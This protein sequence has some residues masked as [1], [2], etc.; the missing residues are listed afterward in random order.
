MT[1][2]VINIG[3][4]YADAA[5]ILAVDELRTMDQP[6]HDG[7][8]ALLKALG[9]TGVVAGEGEA[10]YL[11][12]AGMSRHE[13]LE[14]ARLLAALLGIE[15]YAVCWRGTRTHWSV[16]AEESAAL[17]ELVGAG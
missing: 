14:S 12:P 3:Q 2:D 1:Q 15:H 13:A 6:A 17:R 9:S 5:S 7:L 16:P 10:I 4:Q 8:G 11:A